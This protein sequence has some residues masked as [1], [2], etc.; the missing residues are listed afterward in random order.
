[1]LDQIEKRLNAMPKTKFGLYSVDRKGKLDDFQQ[2]VT[3]EIGFRKITPVT[4]W[5]IEWKE[6]SENRET[7]L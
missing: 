2:N 7:S 1:M 3:S 6:D 4:V 5:R